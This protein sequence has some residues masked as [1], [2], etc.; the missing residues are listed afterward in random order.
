MYYV[1]YGLLYLLSLLPMQILYLISDFVYLLVYYVFGYRKGVVRKNL[2]IAFPE[3]SAQELKKIERKFYRNFT[4]NFIETLKMISAG[5]A[6]A[7][8]HFI[9]DNTLFNRLYE[10]GHKVQVYLGHNFNWEIANVAI[11]IHL[12]FVPL[13]VYMPLN[14]QV[15]DKIIHKLRSSSGSILISARNIAAELLPYRDSQYL[16]GLVADQVPGKLKN[17]WWGEFFGKLTPFPKGPEKFGRA[18]ETAIVF[19]AIYKVKRGYYKL[20]YNLATDKPAELPEGE[21]T[22]RYIRFLESAIREHPENW[23]WTHRRW[24][25]EWKEEYV[26]NTL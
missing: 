13:M 20:E 23:L 6:W 3:K 17:A 18:N 9:S 15:F 4:D 11:S 16:I 25:R 1:V 2:S 14:N 24:K 22:R 26:E 8:K 21:V 19:A 5:P 10:K 12:K 7:D